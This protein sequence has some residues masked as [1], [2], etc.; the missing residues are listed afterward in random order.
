MKLLFLSDIK[1]AVLLVVASKAQF[2]FPIESTS[3]FTVND[4]LVQ[5]K[6]V[7]SIPEDDSLVIQSLKVCLYL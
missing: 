6:P 2:S 3:F 4:F 1:R 7:K 5:A